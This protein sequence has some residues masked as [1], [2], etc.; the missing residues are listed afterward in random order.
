MNVR[1]QRWKILWC[2]GLA[3]SFPC[4]VQT[5]RAQADFYKGKTISILQGSSPGGT[6]DLMVQAIIPFLRKYIPG[7]PTIIREYMPGGG[8][9][10]AANHLFRAVRPDGLTIGNIG[11]GLVTH[12][13]LGETGVQ[14][15][16]NKFHYLGSSHSRYHWVFLTWNKAGLSTVEKLRAATGVRIG[17]QTVGHAVYMTGRLF[18]YLIGVNEPSFVT[19]YSDTEIDAAMQQGEVDGRVRNAD[20]IVGRLPHWIGERLVDFHSIINVPLEAKHPHFGYLPE[21]GTFARSK[22]E[23]ELLRLLRDFRQ[24]GSPYILSPGTPGERVAILAAAFRKAYGDPTFHAAF[25]KLVGQDASPLMPEEQQ[26]V[27]RELPDDPRIIEL[28]K[29][30][31]GPAALPPR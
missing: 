28:F 26:K 29:R 24:A 25:K 6:G 1:N 23:R 3:V 19:G 12:A 9:R 30:F 20:A 10:K 16:L 18:A 4:T 17:A 7:D 8:G 15:E 11:L 5:A 22:E 27:I 21:L 31:T 13:T 2:L 14:Y